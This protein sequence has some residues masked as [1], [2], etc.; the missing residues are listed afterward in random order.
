MD[1]KLS[2]HLEKLRLFVAVANAGSINSAAKQLGMTQPPISLSIKTLEKVLGVPLFVRLPRGIRLTAFGR[3][4][5]GL[6]N[7]IFEKLRQ[8]EAKAS[9]PSTVLSGKINIGTYGSIARYYWPDASNYLVKHF[10]ALQVSLSTGRTAA[11]VER[12]LV[13]ELD[14]SVIVE[15]SEDSRLSENLLYKDSY[16]F[17]IPRGLDKNKIASLPLAY[18]P[19]S[20]DQE[21]KTLDDFVANYFSSELPKLHLD[22]FEV[23]LEFV[24]RQVAVAILPLRVAEI[25]SGRKKIELSFVHG[26]KQLTFGPHR[27]FFVYPKKAKSNRLIGIIEHAL[28]ATIPS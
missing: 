25:E 20:K 5:L 27:I 21:G 8:L 9:A 13:G 16:G 10:P 26:T 23:C 24:K 3:E 17:F 18:V 4:L 28:R 1:P 22:D 12:V 7:T 6:T 2:K 19:G 11:L 14:A 15:S